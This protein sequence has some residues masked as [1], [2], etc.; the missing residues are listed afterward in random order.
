MGI[1]IFVQPAQVVL[2]GDIEVIAVRQGK[3]SLQ[4]RNRG[5][6]HFVEQAI[7]VRGLGTAGDSLFDH[8]EAGWYVLAGG[9]RIHELEL[10]KEPCAKIR[11]L[12][13]EVNTES[14][15]FQ[16]RFDIPSGACG[17]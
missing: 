6:V 5:N 16:E 11:T 7:R 3:L 1:P 15:T 14:K 17:Q 10:P 9:F 13:I 8:Q 12:A 4:V 2:Q